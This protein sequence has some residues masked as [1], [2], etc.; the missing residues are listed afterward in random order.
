MGLPWVQ[1]AQHIATLL[2]PRDRDFLASRE[3]ASIPMR[4][5]LGGASNWFSF[6]SQICQPSL[7]LANVIGLSTTLLS[8]RVMQ[9]AQDWLP[10]SIPQTY[11]MVAPCEEGADGVLLIAHL[12]QASFHHPCLFPVTEASDKPGQPGRALARVRIGNQASAV[13][14][15][16]ETAGCCNKP[17]RPLRLWWTGS[18]LL[19][20]GHCS[21]I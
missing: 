11:L 20:A 21:D 13:L 9:P 14:S 1:Q 18:R 7:A 15:A 19:K 12:L 5:W 8:G 17:Y 3:V 2:P 10:I 16:Q 6:S 4:I